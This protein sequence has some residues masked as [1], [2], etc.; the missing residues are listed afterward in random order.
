LAVVY[1]LCGT[2]AS[3]IGREGNRKERIERIE[4]NLN[5]TEQNSKPEARNPKANLKSK[6][7][8]QT[9][10]RNLSLGTHKV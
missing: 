6:S 7:K 8:Y 3:K 9:E 2:D 1:D 5:F 10:T 4:G